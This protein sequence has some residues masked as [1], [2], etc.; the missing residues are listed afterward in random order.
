MRR[1]VIGMVLAAVGCGGGAGEC[2]P[3]ECADICAKEAK[4][5]APAPAKEAPAAAPKDERL[6]DFEK[7]VLADTIDSVKAGVR[8]YDAEG[9]GV[10]K[11]KGRECEGF[12]GADAGQLP[13]GDY[14]IQARLAV[15]QI[16]GDDTWRVHFATKCETI[17]VG[18]D[19][20]ET[21]TPR[22]HDKEYQVR[23]A[24]PD[25]PYRLSPLRRITSPAKGGRQE[26]TYTLTMV[27]P[28]KEEVLKGS[29]TVPA[30]E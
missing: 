3:A 21:R 25:R 17:R 6:T 12:V 26:C 29:Y 22:E 19:G 20:K 11:G 15:P 27:R 9:F 16:G 13:A 30:A 24:G 8:P 2:G 18:A 28:D 23:Y 7:A 1:L 10:C 4:T 14:M 5:A